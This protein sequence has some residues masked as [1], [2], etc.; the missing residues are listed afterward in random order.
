MFGFFYGDEY[1]YIVDEWH[2]DYA[3][4]E[5]DNLMGLFNFWSLS[6]MVESLSDLTYSEE[7]HKYTG[8]N[9]DRDIDNEFVFEDGK[10]VDNFKENDNCD[11]ENNQS[12]E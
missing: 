1:N 3:E 4:R 12:K 8:K 6:Y 10:L 7:T 11:N 9:V 5:L 2:K